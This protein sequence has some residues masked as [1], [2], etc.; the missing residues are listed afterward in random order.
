MGLQITRS[1]GLTEVVIHHGKVNA[2]DLELCHEIATTFEELGADRD[3]GPIVLTGRGSVFSGGV[4]VARILEGDEAYVGSFLTALSEA[5]LAV[6]R[7]EHPVVAAVNGHAIAGG[8]VLARAAD[9]VI[10]GG[11]GRMGLLELAV[12]VPFPAAAMEV[13]RVRLGEAELRRSIMSASAEAFEA[14]LGGL[15]DQLVDADTLGVVAE[16]QARRLGDVPASS[17]ALTKAV[18]LASVD[19]AVAR[20]SERWDQEVARAWSS[21]EVQDAIRASVNARTERG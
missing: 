11:T 12:G 13:L 14:H 19:R 18:M 7:C 2:L 20:S 1:E 17:F 8:A 3:G 4:D 10:A 5:F 15:V 6:L 16:G 9:V 21:S